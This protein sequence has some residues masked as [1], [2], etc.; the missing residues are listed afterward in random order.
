MHMRG[1]KR[2]PQCLYAFP[3]DT[4]GHVAQGWSA[5]SPDYDPY[6]A[7]VPVWG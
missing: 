4:A 7:S 5:R 1:G 6:T 2:N 3:E